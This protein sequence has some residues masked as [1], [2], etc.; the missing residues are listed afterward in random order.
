MK[1]KKTIRDTSKKKKTLRRCFVFVGPNIFFFFISF[2]FHI[3][4]LICNKLVFG[5]LVIW[6]NF[7]SDFNSESIGRITLVLADFF[8][9]QFN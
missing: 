3:S 1:K 8:L 7:C 9:L 6:I 2:H 4:K 5:F